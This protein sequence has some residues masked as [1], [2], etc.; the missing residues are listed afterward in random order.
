MSEN[1]EVA[2]SGF[3]PMHYRRIRLSTNEVEELAVREKV[4]ESGGQ[5]N[6]NSECVGTHGVLGDE[7]NQFATTESWTELLDAIYENDRENIKQWREDMSFILLFSGLLAIIISVFTVHAQGLLHEDP[8]AQSVELLALIASLLA[9]PEPTSINPIL[10]PP[11][12]SPPMVAVKINTLWVISLTLTLIVAFFAITV[13][14]WLR[15]IPTLRQQS[16]RECIRQRQFRYLGLR[17]WQ[18]HTIISLLPAILQIAVV[19]FLVGLLYLL[20]SLNHGILVAYAI[21]AGIALLLYLVSAVLPAILPESPYK[22][23][24]VPT[25]LAITRAVA[26]P[27]VRSSP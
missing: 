16:I 22:S 21:V 4:S 25:V 24:F 26:V 19:L 10:D 2:T 7:E 5:V 9:S 20:Q 17:S 8:E 14:Q 15:R 1:V 23:L 13:Q 6:G 3:L 18:V 11:A 27:I 12:F